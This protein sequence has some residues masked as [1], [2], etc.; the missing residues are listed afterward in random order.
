MRITEIDTDENLLEI[1]LGYRNDLTLI[2]RFSDQNNVTHK[3]I[4][5]LRVFGEKPTT[6]TLETRSAK[7]YE[8]NSEVTH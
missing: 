1:D 8:T 2:V 6:L 4:F 7:L 3:R 5:L